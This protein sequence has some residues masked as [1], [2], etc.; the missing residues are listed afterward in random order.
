[1]NIVLCGTFEDFFLKK[2]N[3]FKSFITVSLL[4]VI[5]RVFGFFRDMS[6]SYVYGASGTTDAFI[7][8]F[9]IPSIILSFIGSAAAAVFIPMYRSNEK[10]KD[11]FTSNILNIIVLIAL[12]FSVIFAVYPGA[13]VKL[14]AIGF[15]T[16]TFTIASRFTRI[17]VWCAIPVLAAAVLKSYLQL[18]DAFFNA[19]AATLITDVFVV[20]FILLSGHFQ[21]LMLSS[22][23][24]LFGNFLYLLF[25][26]YST[27]KR[28]FVYKPY[29]NFR[30]DYIRQMLVL[31]TPI[32]ISTLIGELNQIIDR[33]FAST[34]PSG[35]VSSL[36]YAS[37]LITAITAS[38]GTA[39][40]TV[41]FPAMSESS[42]SGEIA[43]TKK[44]VKSFFLN[45]IPLLLPIMSAMIMLS[46]PI[47]GLLFARGAFTAEDTSRTAECMRMYAPCIIGGNLNLIMIKAFHSIKNTRTPAVISVLSLLVNIVLNFVLIKPFAHNGL[48]FATSVASILMLIL[49]YSALR[50]TLGGFGLTAHT[51]EFIKSI[52]ATAMMSILFVIACKLFP[53]TS[54]RTAQTLQY[55]IPT[56]MCGAAVYATVHIVL[57]TEFYSTVRRS[58][59]TLIC[60]EVPRL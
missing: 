46:E 42:A 55:F 19:S 26:L 6:L 58:L 28:G 17:M 39:A 40:V 57:K 31:M 35:G 59:F 60:R 8:A 29:I 23:G 47:I 54:S 56:V 10:Y 50:K 3:F 53:M 11:E 12:M 33:N 48:A 24:V 5:A 1:M 25:L 36:S 43:E 37:K 38:V 41:I 2:K 51:G 20:A 49:M 30:D 27:K 45:T 22:L 16:E 52:V 14:F 4:S 44:Y 21:N 18:N 9:T 13:L 7:V 32:M 15:D 34:L